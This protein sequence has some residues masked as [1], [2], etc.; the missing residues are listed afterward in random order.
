MMFLFAGPQ[1]PPSCVRN[2]HPHPATW[3]GNMR[4]SLRQGRARWNNSAALHRLGMRLGDARHH[5]LAL[6]LFSVVVFFG[7][8]SG[9]RHC[10]PCGEMGDTMY[11]YLRAGDGGRG[12]DT[13]SHFFA[14][15]SLEVLRT[16]KFIPS[17]LWHF[18]DHRSEDASSLRVEGSSP[19]FLQGPTHHR[20]RWTPP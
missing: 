19:P 2:Q 18:S 3:L 6:R 14:N 8:K 12:E 5:L 4:A 20:L 11:S 15:C 7:A 1:I 13:D 16:L 10:K 17:W 9:G